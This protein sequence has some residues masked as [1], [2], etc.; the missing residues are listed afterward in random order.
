MSEP[1]TI[2]EAASHLRLDA[3]ANGGA[4]VRYIRDAREWVERYTGHILI[5]REVVEHFEGFRAAA[6]RA[7]PVA[8]N[9][10]LGVAYVDA[11]GTPVALTGARLD[12]SQRPARVMASGGPFWPFLRADQRYTVTIEAG[13]ASADDVPGNMHRAMLVLIGAYDA[14]REGGDLFAAAEKTAR[15]LCGSYRMRRV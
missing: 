1:I 12:V 6:L 3:V 14:D 2:E 7:W 13:Y 9:A 11:A 10:P 15:K 8:T 4:L 5:R